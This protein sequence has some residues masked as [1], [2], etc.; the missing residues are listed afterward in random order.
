MIVPQ[1]RTRAGATVTSTSR[2]RIAST[3]PMRPE[4]PSMTSMICSNCPSGFGPDKPAPR[5]QP[6]T[7]TLIASTWAEVSALACDGGLCS[8]ATLRTG[9]SPR[10]VVPGRQP[11]REAQHGASLLGHAVGLVRRQRLDELVD[12]AHRD[13]AQQQMLECGHNELPLM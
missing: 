1:I 11:E 12:L 3:S 13:L 5:R 8:T 4:V 6:Q 9:F 2:L 10:G 7:A